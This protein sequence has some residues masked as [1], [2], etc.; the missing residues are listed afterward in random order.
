MKEISRAVVLLFLL[1]T[2]LMTQYNKCDDSRLN[3]ERRNY[4]AETRKPTAPILLPSPVPSPLPF[5]LTCHACIG[6][7]AKS[8]QLA[9]LTH[10]LRPLCH[11]TL[12]EHLSPD[13]PSRQS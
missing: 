13:A 7:A 6:P 2:R 3:S 8:Q 11:T 9:A 10:S 12:P 1:Y 4:S 5:S